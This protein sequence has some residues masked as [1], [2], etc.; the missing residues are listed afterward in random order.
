MEQGRPARRRPAPVN[1]ASRPAANGRSGNGI[2]DS[3][4]ISTH[5]EHLP[6]HY[7][8]HGWGLESHARHVSCG[9]V[10]EHKHCADLRALP[11]E[12]ASMQ[13]LAPR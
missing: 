1:G 6:E 11:W 8:P 7:L 4:I 9:L 12:T 13:L 10:S 2:L 3:H 5:G